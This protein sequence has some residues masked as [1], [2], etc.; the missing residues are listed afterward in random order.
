[1]N[2]CAQS[3][4]MTGGDE[5]SDDPFEKHR[6]RADSD[7]SMEG[8]MRRLRG[9]GPEKSVDVNEEAVDGWV[10][11]TEPVERVWVVIKRGDDTVTV[12]DVA[13]RA[14]VSESDATE[15]LDQMTTIGIVEAT[16]EEYRVPRPVCLALESC[17]L[18]DRADGDHIEARLEDMRSEPDPDD[19]TRRNRAIAKV[20]VALNNA[21]IV[22]ENV[23]SEQ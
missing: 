4:G 10:S 9:E 13:S 6:G 17:R 22:D 5:D 3:E 12:D 23:R 8:R 16:G 19:T 7:D 21:A 2:E 15:C 1:M 18:L 14:R 11:D 20:A